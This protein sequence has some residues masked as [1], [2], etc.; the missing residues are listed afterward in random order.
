MLISKVCTQ[1]KIKIS[2]FWHWNSINEASMLLPK[3]VSKHF[4]KAM[5]SLRDII[6]NVLD[7]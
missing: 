2:V 7:K 6:K 5:F 1:I 4:T 3:D